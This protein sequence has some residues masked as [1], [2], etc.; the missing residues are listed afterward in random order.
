MRSL[1]MTSEQA[2]FLFQEVKERR[3]PIV[4]RSSFRFYDGL[5]V[6]L[7]HIDRGGGAV[8]RDQPLDYGRGIAQAAII[9]PAT[10]LAWLG[11]AA[12]PEP[13]EPFGMLPALTYKATFWKPVSLCRVKDPLAVVR[14]PPAALPP[15]LR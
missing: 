6:T 15:L 9:A 8:L 12:V 11:T 2:A 7:A 13:F 4:G 14:L 1:I 5:L 10:H 3:T